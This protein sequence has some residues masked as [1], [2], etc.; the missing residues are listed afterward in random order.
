MVVNGDVQCCQKALSMLP[1]VTF[2]MLLVVGRTDQTIWWRA[3]ARSMTGS[4]SVKSPA[5][6]LQDGKTKI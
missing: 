2:S 5:A 4:S 6:E 1:K 3:H